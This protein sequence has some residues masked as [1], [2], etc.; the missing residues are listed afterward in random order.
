[1]EGKRLS[2]HKVGAPW[3]QLI[4]AQIRGLPVSSFFCTQLITAVKL[5][6]AESQI[7]PSV[8]SRVCVVGK[9]HLKIKILRL[10]N[11]K[12]EQTFLLSDAGSVSAGA[13]TEIS[14]VMMAAELS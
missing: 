14:W 3:W 9:S 2:S 6:P 1:M 10:R 11:L 4:A 13:Q 12:L 7:L 5:E 8:C